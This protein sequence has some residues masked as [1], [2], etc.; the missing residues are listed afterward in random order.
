M[1]PGQPSSK[2]GKASGTD[3]NGK[4][5]KDEAVGSALRSVYHSAVGEPIPDE[6]LDLLRK[7]D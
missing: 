5:G 1:Q 7:L 3:D 6:M 4:K 2:R